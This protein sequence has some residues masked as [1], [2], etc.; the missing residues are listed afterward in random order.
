VKLRCLR[1]A[2]DPLTH[3]AA[4]LCTRGAAAATR[5]AA[6]DEL[7]ARAARG[8]T[9]ACDPCSMVRTAWTWP[10]GTPRS[11][12]R[13]RPAALAPEGRRS[14][15]PAAS[16]LMILRSR[17]R[18]SSWSAGNAGF[19]CSWASEAAPHSLRPFCAFFLD[20]LELWGSQKTAS[21]PPPSFNLYHGRAVVCQSWTRL[22]ETCVGKRSAYVGTD[23]MCPACAL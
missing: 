3:L 13:R 20:L 21:T 15:P 6:V 14:G 19:R 17:C 10:P 12:H 11:P 2:G 1:T 4:P 23:A 16:S 7:P 5:A 9:T 22:D 18:Y 8:Q